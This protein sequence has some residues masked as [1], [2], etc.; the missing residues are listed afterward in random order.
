MYG[1]YGFFI[2]TKN[3]YGMYENVS[4]CTDFQGKKPENPYNFF[5]IS[6]HQKLIFLVKM[7]LNLL[8]SFRI[9]LG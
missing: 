4:N 8:S 9:I 5:S 6:T 3:L 1:F 7:K 2:V